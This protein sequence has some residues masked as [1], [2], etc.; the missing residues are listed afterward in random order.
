[1]ASSSTNPAQMIAGWLG[2]LLIV[3]MVGSV[4]YD[5]ITT[6][7]AGE[8]ERGLMIKASIAENKVRAADRARD[9]ARLKLSQLQQAQVSEADI[10]NAMAAV[11]RAE[12]E[13]ESAQDEL[14]DIGRS[15]WQFW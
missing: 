9:A 5:R 14:D 15:W 4:A 2:L 8:G 1:M 7:A 12:A 11:E 10:A 3:V 13:F 6:P